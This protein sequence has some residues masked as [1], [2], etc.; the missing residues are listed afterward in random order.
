MT[1]MFLPGIF[2]LAMVIAWTNEAEKIFNFAAEARVTFE[3]GHTGEDR[4]EI[5]QGLGLNLSILDRK[6]C[7]ALQEPLEHIKNMADEIRAISEK[8]DPL[9]LKTKTST[10]RHWRN[11]NSSSAVILGQVDEVRTALIEQLA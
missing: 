4:R 3:T 2:L 6:L 9:K 11:P 7:V 5:L 8:L 1:R 10:R